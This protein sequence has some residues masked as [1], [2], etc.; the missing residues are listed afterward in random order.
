MSGYLPL[1]KA[2]TF[3]AALAATVLLAPTSASAQ[4]GPLFVYAEPDAVRTEL[5]SFARLALADK[6]DQ[7]RLQRK[8]GAAVARVCLRNVGHFGVQDRDYYACERNA[9][10]AASP[11]IA[12]AISRATGMASNIGVLNNG[13]PIAVSAIRISA[14]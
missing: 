12:A 7:R 8:V 6:R 1:P 14:R 2:A 3:A 9:W 13:T 5:V 4:Q 10:N 11:Q